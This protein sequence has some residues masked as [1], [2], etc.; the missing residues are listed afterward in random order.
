MESGSLSEIKMVATIRR[1]SHPKMQKKTSS[2]FF[3]AFSTTTTKEGYLQEKN[4]AFIRHS[5]MILS[6]NVC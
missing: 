2:I 5:F 3:F 6:S 4:L 1:R